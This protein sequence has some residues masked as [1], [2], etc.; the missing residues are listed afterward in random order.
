MFSEKKT[1]RLCG[2][3]S[4]ERFL[5]LGEQ[6]LANAFLSRENFPKEKRYPLCIAR[7]TNHEC[8]FV[9]LAHV[10]DPE[11]LFSDYVY[12]S[13]T[14]PSFVKHFEE[15]AE[16][17]AKRVDLKNALT[18]DIGSNDGILVKPLK[19]LGACAL[20]IDPA[21]GIAERANKEGLETLTGYFTKEFAKKLA[22]ERG[23]AILITANNVFAH[24]DDLD[25]VVRGVAALLSKKG[26]FV[27]EVP[28]L[29]DF[30]EKKLFDLTYH[31]HLSYI[32]LRPLQ[33][34]FKRNA[35]RIVDVEKVST[36]GGSV[37]IMVAH[38]DA[39]FS[40]S[41]IV[42][43]MIKDEEKKGLYESDTYKK[44]ADNIFENRTALRT[45]LSDLKK[46]GK[47]IA[48]YGA[49]AKGNTLLNFMDIGPDI[50]EYIVDD[51]PLKQGLY[52]PGMH[53]L[54]APPERLVEDPPD[55][56]FILAWNF[57]TPIMEKTKDFKTH[58]GKYII[59]VPAA[60]I[61]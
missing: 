20:G 5:D 3:T 45:L 2:G 18:L 55:Y 28:Y 35:M 30:L 44:F 14:S 41:P 11:E 8:G 50:L 36:H 15:Y 37:R 31:E 10:V 42:G 21:E 34:F 29:V 24:I 23:E 7:C 52:S 39:D 57:A 60:R 47:K 9:Q 6:P 58:G 19:K 4:L 12:V 32:A 59:P 17:M 33:A 25:D 48:G 40:E 46:K 22:A 56:L 16:S 26:L 43:Q 27:I 54:I 38:D 53:V 49:P 61:V 1:C 51:N 13:S